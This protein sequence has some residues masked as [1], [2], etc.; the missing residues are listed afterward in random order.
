MAN[1][2]AHAATHQ[3]WPTG[4]KPK[5]TKS[6]SRFIEIQPSSVLY[7][8]LPSSVKSRLS[9]L[10]SLRKSAGTS[11]Q[12]GRVGFM[13]LNC[14]KRP[15]NSNVNS[16]T[17]SGMRTPPPAYS[18][19]LT[20]STT[21]ASTPDIDDLEC[22][23]GQLEAADTKSSSTGSVCGPMCLLGTGMVTGTNIGTSIDW[24]FAAQGRSLLS[25][26]IEESLSESQDAPD[27]ELS[28][29]R[30][31]YIH[32]VTYLLRGLPNDLS[33]EERLGLRS[34][35][36]SGVMEPLRLDINGQNLVMIRGSE[37]RIRNRASSPPSLL[38]RILASLV[39]QLFVFAHFIFPHV[40]TLLRNAYI[41]E[42]NNRL[43]ER[44]FAK[45][46]DTV[47]TVGKKG[48]EFGEAVAR[49]GDGKL[50]QALNEVAM[51]CAEGVAGGIYEGVGEGMVIVGAKNQN[52]TSDA[53]L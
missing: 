44:M 28:F 31:L 43:S 37:S 24:K 50:G 8:M 1:Q 19:S 35:L 18:P 4:N 49:I 5:N 12:K 40:K 42:R 2:L 48:I 25:S 27:K 45:S 47:D 39:I 51:W 26:A 7:S 32:S 3:Q 36:P 46:I 22:L 21:R 38:H 41:Y 53:R 52:L 20:I 23:R 29:T 14:K 11:S 9:Q 15:M 17:S 13:G 16:S 30:Q 6:S 34:A 33:A 10:P